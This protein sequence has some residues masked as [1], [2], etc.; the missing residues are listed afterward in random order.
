[1]D[2]RFTIDKNTQILDLALKYSKNG[3]K[4]VDV[5]G[6]PNQ[7]D[8]RD[9]IPLL[10]IAKENGLFVTVHLGEI[11]HQDEEIEKVLNANVVDRIGHGTF[12]NGNQV[13]SLGI[14]LEICLT[15]NLK[16]KIVQDISKHHFHDFHMD[17]HP[18]I[19]C[20]DDKGI[21]QS[22]SSQEY[23][24]ASKAFNLGKKELYDLAYKSVEYIFDTE[25]V[26]QDL[27]RIFKEFEAI[28]RFD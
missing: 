13:K 22:D 25:Q 1:M 19:L 9:L 21:F 27:R 5:C 17:D 7:G 24:L 10:K 8:L 20:T 15:S 26:K 3:V 16:C 4:G 28:E 11:S 12:L 14:P 2:R 23:I 18:V 6:D